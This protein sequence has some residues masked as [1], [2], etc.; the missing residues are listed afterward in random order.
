MNPNP[1]LHRRLAMGLA[2]VLFLVFL[3]QWLLM[4]VALRQLYT[5]SIV[6]RLRHDAEVLYGA[7]QFPENASPRLV[8]ARVSPIYMQPWS[9]HYY[10]IQVGETHFRSRS[11]WDLEL[12][13][14]QPASGEEGVQ[15]LPGPR[16]EPLLTYTGRFAREDQVIFILVAEEVGFSA[17]LINR[18]L[19]WYAVIALLA[20]A[21]LLGLQ[22]VL[23]KRRLQPLKQAGA[24]LQAVER[25]EFRMLA[26][27]GV[28]AEIV[29][30]VHEINQLLA[31]LTDRLQRSRQAGATLA[32]DIRTPL[33]VLMQLTDRPELADH[34]GL[35]GQMQQQIQSIGARMDRILRRVRVAGLQT[36]DWLDLHPELLALVEMMPQ[37]HAHRPL[38]IERVIPEDLVVRIDRE[39]L[40]ELVGNLLD[41]GCKWAR[42]TVRLTVE[43]QPV[44]ITVEDDGPGCPPE[45]FA[46]VLQWGGRADATVPGSGIGLA[47]VKEIATAYLGRVELGRSARLG[48]F[49]VRVT[50]GVGDE[51]VGSV[52]RRATGP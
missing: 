22:W 43:R 6:S 50:L 24:A 11:L 28:P 20:V 7:L 41:N 45:R 23:I 27:A 14:S 52:S 25:G 37:M 33:A 1:S 32:H 49:W 47:L 36:A 19:F 42:E 16:Q 48:G 46:E 51:P 10:H 44:R 34:A 13:L 9:G 3:G 38:R 8:P 39:D 4:S 5:D 30:F 15:T 18:T 21:V 29:P 12:S 35:R 40:L 26:T 2:A 17:R 31:A